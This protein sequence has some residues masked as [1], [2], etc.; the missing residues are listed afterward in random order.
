M[1]SY[2]DLTS[3][4]NHV[5]SEERKEAFEETYVRQVEQGLNP[6]PAN[7]ASQMVYHSDIENWKESLNNAECE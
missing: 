3:F 2:Q 6:V 1:T 7:E 4:G 5:L